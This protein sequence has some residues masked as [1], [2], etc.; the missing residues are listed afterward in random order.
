MMLMI[1]LVS[2]LHLIDYEMAVVVQAAG[3]GLSVFV[4]LLAH[5]LVQ[6]MSGFGCCFLC[7]DI[8]CVVLH[9]YRISVPDVVMLVALLL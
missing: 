7:L 4:V 2:G 5:V 3:V 8:I 9:M 1:V 6:S